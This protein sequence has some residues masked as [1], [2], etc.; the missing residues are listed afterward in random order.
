MHAHEN[1]QINLALSGKVL[2]QVEDE[3]YELNKGSIIRILPN[4]PHG[5]EKKLSA[6]DFRMIQLIAPWT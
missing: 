2:F 5:L 1:E 6:E 4:Q 3:V